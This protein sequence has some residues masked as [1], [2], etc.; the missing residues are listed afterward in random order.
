MLFNSFT[1]LVFLA[2]AL[3]AVAAARR[4]GHKAENWVLVVLSCIFYGWWD[5]RFLG[6]LFFTSCVDF[7]AAQCIETARSPH[8][9]RLFLGW[10]IVTNLTVL[11]FFKYC[12]FFASGIAKVLLPLGVRVPS[13][14]LSIILPVGISFYTFQ[15][16]SY[17][18]DVYRGKLAACRSLRDFL[19][20]ITF[21]PQLVAGPIERG[22]EML[23]QYRRP[24]RVTSADIAEGFYLILW[25]FAKKTVVADNL[26]LKVDRIFAQP[27]F[28]TADVLVGALGFAFQ[29]YADF[30]GYTDIARGL[31]RWLG[32]ELRLNFDLPYF[33]KNPREFWQRWHISLSSWLREY[34][35]FPLGGNRR[36]EARTYANLMI[37]MLLGGLWHGAAWNFVFWGGYQGALLAAHRW[38]AQGPGA[39]LHDALSGKAP[40][41]LP[42]IL[43]TAIMFCFMLYGW[44]LFRSHGSAQ[45][46]A[47]N[48]ALLHWRLP[49]DV[50]GRIA[51]L[52]PYIGLVAFVDAVTYKTGDALFLARLSPPVTALFYLFLFYAI[53]VLGVTNGAQFIYFAF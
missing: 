33:S 17:T 39:A 21:F 13:H 6:L 12:N 30:S 51:K 4:I 29:I 3:I 8:A 5:W 27:A 49:P 36:G 44:L 32:I 10:S 50:L 28:T 14:L 35:Y 15:A 20:Y 43:C 34:L 23:P 22:G 2:I 42:R 45:L 31:A 9:K 26:A 38:Y 7:I 52:M 37:T 24:R 19:T 48:R 1:F 18:I 40:A 41:W 16:M 46:L 47:A 53:V 25:G 11:G